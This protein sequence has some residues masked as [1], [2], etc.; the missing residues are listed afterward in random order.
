M[1]DSKY[2]KKNPHSNKEHHDEFTSVKHTVKRKRT[3][4]K[5]RKKRKKVDHLKTF[6]SSTLLICLILLIYE[7]F[8]LPQWYLPQ[9]I[10][11]N[12]TNEKV[13]I[14]NNKIIPTYVINNNLK[15]V[16]VSKLPIFLASVDP[17]KKELYKIPVVKKVYV[18]RYGFPARVQI[19]IRERVPIAIIKTDINNKPIAFFTSDNVLVTNKQ[20][21]NLSDTSSLINI[22]TTTQGLKTDFSPE[23]FEEIEKI[24]QA[25]E[26]YSNEKVEYIDLR[27]PNDVF[28]KIKTT[29]I[30][31]GTIDNTVFERIKRIYTILPQITEVNSKIKYVDLSWDRVN[32]LKLQ[33]TK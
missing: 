19:I 4:R 5:L 23:K 16:E 27:K 1:K 17:I 33:K 2:Y 9:D 21:M 6:L 30:R 11:T 25:V 12:P 14:L 20:Y 7:F 22:I 29:N 8:Q 18:R 26:T 13:E 31:L 10:F 32:Y 28:V 15:N 3:E 24:I